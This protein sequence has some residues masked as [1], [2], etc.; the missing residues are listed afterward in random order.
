[1]LVGYFNHSL[2]Q[3]SFIKIAKNILSN[4][5]DFF[6]IVII[7]FFLY[8]FN[9]NPLT[10]PHFQIIQYTLQ[11]VVLYYNLNCAKV[12]AAWLGKTHSRTSSGHRKI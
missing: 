8:S 4:I 5:F 3:K 10:C 2:S 1:M 7:L 9:K 12:Q 6:L 11:E